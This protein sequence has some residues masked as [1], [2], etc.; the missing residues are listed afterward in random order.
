MLLMQCLVPSCQIVK[1]VTPLHAAGATIQHCLWENTASSTELLFK[2][3]SCSLVMG[4]N[5]GCQCSSPW[6][7]DCEIPPRSANLIQRIVF[8]KYVIIYEC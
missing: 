1:D 8:L 6:K 7:G 5:T 2:K 4:D 3:R